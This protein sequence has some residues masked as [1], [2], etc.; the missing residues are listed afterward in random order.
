[1]A[2]KQRFDTYA[3]LGTGVWRSSDV[4][5]RLVPTVSAAA[6]LKKPSPGLGRVF[7]AA[8]SSALTVWMVVGKRRGNSLLLGSVRRQSSVTTTTWQSERYGSS[9]REA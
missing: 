1:M 2:S 8:R 3:I 9:A 6:R 4:A 5:P 7:N